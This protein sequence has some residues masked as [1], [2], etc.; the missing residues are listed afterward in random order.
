MNPFFKTQNNDEL[1]NYTPIAALTSNTND[2][3]IKAR[4]SRKYDRKSWSNA[5]G[6]GYLMNIELVD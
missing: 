1:M 6:T 4:I 2:W 3:I 5:R